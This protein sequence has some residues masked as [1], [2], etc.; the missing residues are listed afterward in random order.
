M[1]FWKSHCPL[2]AEKIQFLKEN[3]SSLSCILTGTIPVESSSSFMCIPHAYSH[4]SP[5][6]EK[7]WQKRSILVILE[8]T[9]MKPLHTYTIHTS[10]SLN[11]LNF[12]LPPAT[13][14]FL[15]GFFLSTECNWSHRVF[16]CWESVAGLLCWELPVRTELLLGWVDPVFF[17]KPEPPT[18][19]SP[20]K[21]EHY[22]TKFIPS[23]RIT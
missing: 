18:P 15:M 2:H 3:I 8:K 5:C 21:P 10:Q 9:N 12:L 23:F 7:Q 19:F 13:H 22:I 14:F 4:V 16:R 11:I 17:L 20:I 6:T 1:M